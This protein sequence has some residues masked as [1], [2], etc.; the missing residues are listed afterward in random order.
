MPTA[1]PTPQHAPLPNRPFAAHHPANH[2]DAEAHHNIQPSNRNSSPAVQRAAAPS[3]AHKARTKALPL[4]LRTIAIA[5]LAAVLAS[6][7]TQ[8]VTSK[9]NHLNQHYAEHWSKEITYVSPTTGGRR[10]VGLVRPFTF[11][12]RWNAGHRGV[13]LALAPGAPVLAAGDGIVAFAGI[14]AGVPNVS[15]DHPGGV[16]TT[17]QPVTTFLK[18]GDPVVAGTPI[19]TFVGSDEHLDALHWGAKIGPDD[20]ID[21]L[22]LLGGRPIRLKPVSETP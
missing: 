21:P 1:I 15:I 14:V 20:Y 6:P 19:G 9:A 18:V 17:Y 16:R 8:A 7:T 4:G 13:D 11:T 10:A 2:D 5:I 3:T 22:R 12:G